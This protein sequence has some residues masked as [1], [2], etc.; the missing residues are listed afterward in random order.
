MGEFRQVLLALA[1][2]VA[3]RDG[4]VHER[5]A[6][7][8]KRDAT[9]GD[10]GELVLGVSGVEAQLAGPVQQPVQVVA[11]P[12]D[13]AVPHVCDGVGQI[14][15]AESG[16]EYRDLGVLRGDELALDPGHATGVGAGRV[17]LVVAVLDHRAGW[18]VLADGAWFHG[19]QVTG[20][21]GWSSQRHGAQFLW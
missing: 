10:L 4:Q 21:D 5:L 2:S 20:S 1:L 7:L 13:V 18:G 6:Q 3:A 11:E 17:Q 16:V 19:H 9:L 14:G 8:R 12:K 15:V